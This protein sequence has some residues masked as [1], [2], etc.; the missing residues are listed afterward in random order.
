MYA[1]RQD[2]TP[3]AKWLMDAGPALGGLQFLAVDSALRL[4]ELGC[5]L[6]VFDSSASA[7]AFIEANSSFL[8]KDNLIVPAP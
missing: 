3:D 2:Y 1:I 4:A 7:R 6:V 8:G 5:R